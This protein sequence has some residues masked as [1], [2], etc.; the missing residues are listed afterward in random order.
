MDFEKIELP[1]ILK[2]HFNML[3]DFHHDLYL[4]STGL[5]NVSYDN[6]MILLMGDKASMAKGK[7]LLPAHFEILKNF[8]TE[9]STYEMTPTFSLTK[10]EKVVVKKLLDGSGVDLKFVSQTIKLSGTKYQISQVKESLSFYLD[11]LKSMKLPCAEKGKEG[12]NSKKVVNR[13]VYECSYCSRKATSSYFTDHVLKHCKRGKRLEPDIEKRRLE[14]ESIK[15]NARKQQS[16]TDDQDFAEGKKVDMKVVPNEDM[17]NTLVAEEENSSSRKYWATQHHEDA[18]IAISDSQ[19]EN[20]VTDG[21]HTNN[22]DPCELNENLIDDVIQKYYK[23]MF[24]RGSG[25]FHDKLATKK[26]KIATVRKVTEMC[27]V[28]SIDEFVSRDTTQDIIDVIDALNISDSSKY[29]WALHIILF[30]NYCQDEHP[31]NNVGPFGNGKKLNRILR[32]G[33]QKTGL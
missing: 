4:K 1:N 24:K 23:S 14:A 11:S 12:K 21:G 33:L 27:S 17:D 26:A 18:A 5:K 30:L 7:A 3:K 32:K 15:N 31:S 10:D 22:N 8:V 2:N 16:V 9:T 19:L 28:H 13:S 25:F 29:Y 20:D 6:G